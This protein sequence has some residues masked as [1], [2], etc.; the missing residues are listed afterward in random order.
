MMNVGGANPR[1]W[2]IAGKITPMGGFT[3]R[4]RMKK[5]GLST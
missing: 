2:S 5:Q 4:E 3:E 1:V